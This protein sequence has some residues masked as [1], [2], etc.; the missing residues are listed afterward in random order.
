MNLKYLFFT[1]LS[2][3]LFL[4]C[5]AE[6]DESSIV[7]SASYKLNKVNSSTKAVTRPFKSKA[8]G[9]WFIVEPTDCDG[10]LQYS[11]IGNGNATHLGSF[12]IQGKMCTYPP[13]N[14]YFFTIKY[15]AANGDELILESVDVY[16]NEVGLFEG[17]VFECVGGTGRFS[18]SEGNIEVHEFLSVTEFDDTTGLPLAGTF[19][20]MGAGT[21]TF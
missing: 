9:E 19:S 15:I 21:I 13:D 17:G 8:S 2:T 3:I 5:S 18:N 20:N 6:N 16:I 7:E 12:N 11:I 14:L 1:V 4:G 10:L